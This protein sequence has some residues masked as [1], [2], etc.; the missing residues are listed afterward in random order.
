MWAK[1]P[2]FLLI[3]KHC[4]VAEHKADAPDCRKANKGVDYSRHNCR[5]TAE[6]PRYKVK[7]KNA[8]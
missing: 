1:C 7:F 3:L 6:Y 4:C 5:L 8:D 2:H